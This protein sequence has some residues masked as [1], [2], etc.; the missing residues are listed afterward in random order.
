MHILN[1]FF[2]W[3]LLVISLLVTQALMVGHTNKAFANNS[4]LKISK[5][6]IGKSQTVKVGLNK[7][8][9]IDLPGDAH[10]ILVASPTV[11]DAITRTSRRIY[12]FGKP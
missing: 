10:D 2:V 3:T 9:V 6:A 11:A 5:A 12:I 8:M 7:S 4:Y 1:R